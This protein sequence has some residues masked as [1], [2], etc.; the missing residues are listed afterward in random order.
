MKT[1]LDCWL[2]VTNPSKEDREDASEI[3]RALL[4]LAFGEKKSVH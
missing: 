1:L 2:E 3:L 4:E